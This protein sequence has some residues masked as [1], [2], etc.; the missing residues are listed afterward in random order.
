MRCG[1]LARC[2]HPIKCTLKTWRKKMKT[3]IIILALASAPMAMALAFD[4][5][6]NNSEIE[7]EIANLK[8]ESRM[9]KLEIEKNE[10]MQDVLDSYDSEARKTNEWNDL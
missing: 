1:N 9:E 5:E 2:L 4:F 7:N 8:F 6:N 3:L 10:K